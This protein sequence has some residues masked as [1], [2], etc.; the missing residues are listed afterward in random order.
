MSSSR[1]QR[2]F[3]GVPGICLAIMHRLGDVVL[4]RAAPAEAAAEVDLVDLALVRRQA[5]SRRAPPR[6]TPRRPASAPTPRTCPACSAPWRSS[7]PCRRGSGTGRRRPPRPS[8]PR[9]PSAALR[10][11]G[12]VA[13]ERLLGVEARLQHLGDARRSRPWRSGPRPRRSAARRARSWRSTRCRPPPRP[14]CRRP[15][16][17]FFTPFM[18]AH[19]GGV[20][21]LHL[22]AEHRAIP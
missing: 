10:V 20:E 21:A 14:R 13:D 17:T 9:P 15:A 6:T 11:A 22:A 16:R 1:D 2:S 19:R 5:G 4:E 12:L 18:F 7:A 8:S 3:T